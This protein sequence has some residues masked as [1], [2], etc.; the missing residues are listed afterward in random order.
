MVSRIVSQVNATKWLDYLLTLATWATAASIT[1]VFLWIVLSIVGQGLGQLSLDFLL[2]EPMN[3]GRE[4]GIAPILV[5]TLL[6]LGVCLAIALPLGLATA[7]LLAEFTVSDKRL[8]MWVRRS[9][10]FLAGV[11]SIVFGLFGSVFFS[12]VL[13]L[14]FSILSGGLTLACMVLPL[15]IRATEEGLRS[16][17]ASY[18]QGAAA[19]GLSKTTTLFK[20]LLPAAL[21]GLMV[22]LVLS[23]GRAL[24]ETAA[25]I[26]TSGYVDRFPES[27]LDS[28][29]AL[30]IHIFDLS[31]NVPGGDGN[32]AASALV[33]LGVLLGLNGVTAL[34]TW[35]WSV[36]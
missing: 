31:M 6:I 8:G 25:L 1:A 13:G 28:G 26:F 3:A 16:Q 30:S 21:P 20:I 23:M 35:R 14:G 29:R 12:K 7:L 2:S 10:D 5:S 9:L 19:L 33:L 32:A 24:A 27:L 18:R 11:P 15:L 36:R 22:G 34:I 17:P 4:G